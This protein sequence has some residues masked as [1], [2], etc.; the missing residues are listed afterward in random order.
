MRK[1][2]AIICEF[3]PF[4]N[5]H[6][7]LFSQVREIFGADAVLIAI[8]SGNYVQ[9]G[10]P[11]VL[12]KQARARCAV[13]CG[14]DL[15]FELPFPY[16]ASS[17]ERFATA[18]VHIA[19]SLGCVDCLVFGSEAAD[20]DALRDIAIRLESDAFRRS[21]EEIDKAQTIG[22]A[23]KTCTAYKRLYGDLPNALS[24]PNSIL[25]I[26]YIRA[27]IRAKSDI[28]PIAV[29]RTGM[30]HDAE[31][32]DADIVS[33]SA[34]RHLLLEN[35]T[36]LALTKLPQKTKEILVE[37]IGV[38]RAPVAYEGLLHYA[39]LYFRLHGPPD[40]EEVEGLGDGLGD[41]FCKAAWNSGSPSDFF[42]KIRTKRYTDAYLR[43]AI[44]YGLFGVKRADLN[45]P[46]AYTQLLAMT[47]EGQKVLSSIRRT[48]EISILTKPADY[49]ALD[50]R[51][52]GAAELSL[53][54]DSLYCALFPTQA[55]ASDLLRYSP[56]RKK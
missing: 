7:Y 47:I 41:R 48:A 38:G 33:A 14:A 17:A 5:G 40:W 39:L 43:R 13:E 37:E 28:I 44:L 21:Y 4:H 12:C 35:E 53:R 56:W 49:K 19:K 54:A 6:A 52:R 32:T 31:G 16:S 22:S 50:E 1:T 15:V 55:A 30:P 8:M 20:V 2:V 24:K 10:T 36:E 11:A 3:N 34:I 23:Q 26:E 46:P 27:L 18:G 9:R 51:A 45:T 42:E 29:P 25:G